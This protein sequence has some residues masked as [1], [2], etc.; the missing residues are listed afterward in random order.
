MNSKMGNPTENTA[1][2]R[3]YETLGKLRLLWNRLKGKE[4]I[5]EWDAGIAFEYLILRAFE[6][7]GAKVAYS[8]AVELLGKKNVE[9]IDGL[10]SIESKNLHVLAESKE[11]DASIPFGPMAKM[12]NQ[13]MRRPSGLIGSVFTTSTFTK[14]AT[15]LAHF[16]APH[17]I[18][19]WTADDIEYCFENEYFVGSLLAKYHYALQEGKP[20]FD[21]T[22]NDPK[23]KEGK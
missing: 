20:N 15:I 2:I 14:E 3:S 8:Y 6:I 12:R 16:F 22:E 10:I 18:L 23:S 19:L 13:L 4:I 7:Q 17:T 9:Q 5:A 1:K 21:L 11:W